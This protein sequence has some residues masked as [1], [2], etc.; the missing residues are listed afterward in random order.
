M[1]TQQPT[2]TSPTT[3]SPTTQTP[4]AMETSSNASEMSND[5]YYGWFSAKSAL[6]QKKKHIYSD[7]SGKQV[8]VTCVSRTVDHGCG[9]DD[10]VSV[11]KVYK[12]LKSHTAS[13][14]V[15]K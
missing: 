11:D 1:T 5:G 14:N 15:Y 3:Q 4:S 12:Y 9:W 2:Q 7:K 10:I 6:T 8:V 13:S